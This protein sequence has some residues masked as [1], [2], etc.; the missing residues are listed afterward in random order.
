M[1]LHYLVKYLAFFDQQCLLALFFFLGHPVVTH[2]DRSRVARVLNGV[3]VF[4]C[5][6]VFPQDI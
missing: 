2:A 5:L 6:S 1:L 3:Y 4:V